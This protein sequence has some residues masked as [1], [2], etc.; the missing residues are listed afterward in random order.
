MVFFL[1]TKKIIW[2]SQCFYTLP[3][4][5]HNR[6]TIVLKF[7]KTPPLYIFSKYLLKI[8]KCRIYVEFLVV[9]FFIKVFGLTLRYFVKY[10]LRYVKVN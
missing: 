7:Y 4:V 6:T 8:V 1:F 3:E 9:D 5:T 2:K 10:Y